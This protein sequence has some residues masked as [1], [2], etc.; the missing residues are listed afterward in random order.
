MQLTKFTDIGLRVLMHLAAGDPAASYTARGLA[1][2]LGVPYAHV[3]KVV[4]RLS[5]IGVVHARRGRSGGLRITDLGRNAGVGWVTR[6]LEGDDPVVDCDGPT[7]C[8]LRRGCRLRGVLAAAR[9]A[10]YASLDTLTVA[11]L[12]GADGLPDGV[13]PIPLIPR[14]EQARDGAAT[15]RRRTPSQPQQ[16]RSR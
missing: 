16:N 11:D 7:P 2:E 3:A 10:F 1:E 4:S 5:E 15:G 14:A 9:E 6:A 8:T 12:S 13:L